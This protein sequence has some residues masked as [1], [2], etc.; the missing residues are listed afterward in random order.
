M[1]YIST[2][3]PNFKHSTYSDGSLDLKLLRIGA[4]PFWHKTTQHKQIPMTPNA[5]ALAAVAFLTFLPA[6]L[7]AQSTLVDWNHTWNYLHPTAGALPA[8]SGTTTPHPDGTTPWYAVASQFN[9]S[10]SG[11]SF[12]TAGAGFGAGAGA[13]PI[14]YGDLTYTTTP[15]PAP[16]EFAGLGTTLTIPASGSRRTGYFRTTFTVPSNGQFYITPEIRYILDDGGFIYLDG[17]P[18]LRVNMA[19]A[20]LDDY[21]TSA[22]GT[23]NTESQIRTANLNL[24]VGSNTGGNSVVNPAIGNNAVVLKTITRLAPGPHTLAV[25][26]HNANNTSSDLALAVQLRTTVTNCL[27]TATSSNSTRDTKNT[28]ANAADDTISTS[29]TVTPEGTVGSG[30][31]VT[32]PVGSS[33]IGRTGAYSTPVSITNI[34]IAEFAAGTLEL[35][36]ADSANATCNTTVK[37]VPQRIIASNNLLGTNLPLS[38]IGKISVPGWTIDDA[39]RTLTMNNPAGDG[40]RY[41]LTSQVLNTT[42]QPDLQFSGNLQVVDTSSGNEIED[43]FVAY[44]IING[45]T[46][47]PVNLISRYDLLTPDGVMSAEELAPVAGTYD[48]SLNYVIPASANS[49]QLV[50]EGINN[51]TSEIFTISGL[52]VSQA[53]PQLQA[54]AGPVVFNNNGTPNPADDSFSAPFYITRVNLGAST[55]WTSDAT[56]ASGLYSA[57][58]PVNFGPFAPFIPNRTIVLTDALDPTK[59]ATVDITLELPALTVQAPTN[60]VRVENGPGFDDDTVTF[61]V[62]IVGTNGGPGWTSQTNQVTPVSGN[63]GIVTFTVPAPI[64]PG[65]ITFDVTDI[66]YPTVTQTVSVAVPGRYAVGQSDLG[67]SLMDVDTELATNPAIQWINDPVARTLTL[68]NAGTTLRVV[69]SETID[70]TTQGEVYFSARL[71]ALDT[72]AGSNFEAAD[73]FKAELIY[74]VGGVPTTINLISPWD[75]GNGAASTTGTTGGVNGAPDGFLNGYNGAAGTDLENATV[76]ATGAA[77]YNAHKNRDEFNALGEDASALLDNTFLLG[78]TIPANADDVTLVITGQGIGGSESVVLSNVLFSTS[79]TLGDSDSDGIPD[80]YEIANNLNPFD[81]SDRDLDLD[82]D[83]YTNLSEFLAGTAANDAMSFLGIREFTFV[84]N[85]FSTTWSSVP[86]KIYTIQTSLD[87]KTWTNLGADIPAAATPATTTSS[88]LLPTPTPTAADRYF[89]VLVKPELP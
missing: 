27:I 15:D 10:Y 23:G 81:D 69:Q 17:E 25:S 32:G 77:D 34:P 38:T 3:K 82:G 31:V 21:L 18:I 57:A 80:D 22:A 58:K 20:S 6:Q 75:V 59:T 16:A 29:I 88:P 89:R 87:L 45:N 28:P 39:T 66:S 12:T 4:C 42:G 49:V 43:S 11:P 50:I 61:D 35:V 44:L 73:R 7:D 63:F 54:Y 52:T 36:L 40:S 48:Y 78:A 84:N 79:N 76:Y 55:G 14:G 53:P 60:I 86:G 83:G 41:V 85:R 8:G 19:A 68:N 71:Q 70:L 64:F 56:P 30:W 65:T 47:S 9:S 74:N 13:G 24:P 26:V 72:S 1:S 62:Q 46:A 51:S 2:P 37:V 5:T 67:G 33:L